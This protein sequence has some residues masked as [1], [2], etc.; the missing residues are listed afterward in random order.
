MVPSKHTLTKAK[1]QGGALKGAVCI[2]AKCATINSANF[3]VV[4]NAKFAEASILKCCV[5]EM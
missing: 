2:I 1:Q 4:N 5:N 3:E